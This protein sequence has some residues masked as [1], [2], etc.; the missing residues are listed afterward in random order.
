MIVF[1]LVQDARNV[2]GL[3]IIG[4]CLCQAIAYFSLGSAKVIPPDAGNYALLGYIFQF[5]LVSACTW[6]CCL[7]A[8]G[9]YKV[10]KFNQNQPGWR[11]LVTFILSICVPSIFLMISVLVDRFVPPRFSD[12]TFESDFSWFTTDK[13]VV[14][15]IGPQALSSLIGLSICAV[16]QILIWSLN[17][18]STDEWES[19]KNEIKNIVLS[20][21]LLW[22]LNSFCCLIELVSFV[23]NR[24]KQI[25]WMVADLIN[26]MQGIVFFIILV[27]FKPVKGI[28]Q[29]KFIDLIFNNRS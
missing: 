14:F 24:P 25:V 18:N 7:M 6:F 15:F 17:A 26:A 12:Q 1:L 2:R 16:A 23:V 13:K 4:Y 20:N 22:T 28:I 3:L 27:C 5:F 19:E 9:L 10:L 8:E 21:T 29:G 11:V